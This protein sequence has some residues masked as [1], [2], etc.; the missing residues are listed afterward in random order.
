M[1]T[2]SNSF[3]R[4]DEIAAAKEAKAMHQFTDRCRGA[5]PE[6]CDGSRYLS[7]ERRKFSLSIVKL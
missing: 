5:Q 1:N 2:L 4:Q 7:Q 3:S 6:P